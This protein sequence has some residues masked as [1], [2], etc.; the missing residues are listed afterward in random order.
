MTVTDRKPWTELLETGTLDN[1]DFAVDPELATSIKLHDEEVITIKE[2]ITGQSQGS[3]P[4]E[5]CGRR[6]E[7]VEDGRDAGL[8]VP[9]AGVS[10]LG[11]R[12]FCPVA[13]AGGGGTRRLSCSRIPEVPRESQVGLRVAR[14]LD[15]DDGAGLDRVVRFR[16]AAADH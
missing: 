15:A 9:G 4:R 12:F 1:D 2:I 13:D 8:G 3:I 11:A 7:D 14:W 16:R 10:V 6:G 5:R